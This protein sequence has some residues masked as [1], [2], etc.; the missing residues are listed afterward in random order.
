LNLKQTKKSGRSDEQK[1]NASFQLA[2]LQN[3]ASDHQFINQ[4]QLAPHD[5]HA[6]RFDPKIN[7]KLL[8][9]LSCRIDG[10]V[11]SDAVGGR[12]TLQA[13]VVRLIIGNVT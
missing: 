7:A 11:E 3:A 6:Y 13:R 12:G 2:T 10:Y 4:I 1:Y 9:G 5:R 8:S